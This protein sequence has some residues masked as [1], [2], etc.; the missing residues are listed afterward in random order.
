MIVREFDN[1]ILDFMF[2]LVRWS[3]TLVVSQVLAFI[4]NFYV[5]LII[6]LLQYMF[7]LDKV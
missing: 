5:D 3:L 1:Y 7:I 2:T 4:Y 6:I